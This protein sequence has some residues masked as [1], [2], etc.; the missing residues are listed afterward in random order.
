MLHNQLVGYMVQLQHYLDIKDFEEE[1][2]VMGMSAYG[3][4]N[5]EL[6]KLIKEYYN[7]FDNYTQEEQRIMRTTFVDRKVKFSNKEE[8]RFKQ[9]MNFTKTANMTY[10]FVK[11][12]FDDYKKLMY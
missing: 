8:T 2:I 11:D 4:P 9:H 12:F 6:V 5:D 7:T 1:Y 10:D 3:E